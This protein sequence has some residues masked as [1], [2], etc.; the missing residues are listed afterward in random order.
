MYGYVRRIPWLGAVFL[1]SGCA[2]LGSQPPVATFGA[3]VG[4]QRSIKDDLTPAV[5]APA[6][7]MSAK[8]APPLPLRA[9]KPAAGPKAPAGLPGCATGSECMASLKAMISDPKRSWI[10]QPQSPAEYAN[11]TRLFAY[12]ALQAQ[13]TCSELSLALG[14]IGRAANAFRAPV[15]GVTAAQASRVLALNSEVEKELR[16][17]VSRRCPA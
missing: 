4:Q 13:L 9:P 15:A 10:G 14:E 1:L 2:T 16:A 6:T 17:E 12:R 7:K 8:A 5:T 11:G 3:E